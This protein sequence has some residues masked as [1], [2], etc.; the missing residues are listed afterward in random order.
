MYLY[1]PHLFLYSARPHAHYM[2]TLQQSPPFE[3]DTCYTVFLLL[4]TW[5]G[6]HH[7]LWVRLL[8]YTHTHTHCVST[9][10]RRGSLIATTDTPQWTT[11]THNTGAQ[12]SST[13]CYPTSQGT[14]PI[15]NGPSPRRHAIWYTVQCV[16]V[17]H[18]C[19]V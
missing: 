17:V 1:Y 3:C 16:C 8:L 4:V 18:V 15:C 12:F 19:R 10:C 5:Y 7:I 6:V 9:L 2:F 13:C 11:P 14:F